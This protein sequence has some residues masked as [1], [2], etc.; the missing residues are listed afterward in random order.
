[1][2]DFNKN[3]LD[4]CNKFHTV[5]MLC[6]DCPAKIQCR[7][8]LSPRCVVN[9][10]IVMKEINKTADRWAVIEKEKSKLGVK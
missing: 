10:S 4:M 7:I 3:A 1:M 9:K 5:D 2:S 6:E 8:K